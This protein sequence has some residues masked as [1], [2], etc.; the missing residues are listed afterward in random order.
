MLMKF[1][2]TILLLATRFLA[3]RET[4]GQVAPKTV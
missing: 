4:A 3:A 1:S 2:I